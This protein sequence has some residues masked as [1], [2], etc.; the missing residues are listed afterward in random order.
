MA[1]ALAALLAVAQPDDVA[2]RA[3]VRDSC[4]ECHGADAPKA[5]LDLDSLLRAD[6]TLH[7]VPWE[8]AVR[9]LRTRQ[10]PPPGKTRLSEA[11]YRTL[12]DGLE[13][14]L[15]AARPDPGRPDTL[16]RLSRAEY[17]SAVR[18]LL[19]LEIDAAALLPPDE[20]THGFDSA[21]AGALSA[22]VLDRYLSAA[23]R[24]SRLALGRVGR[25]PGGDT[26]RVRP[27]LT[28]EDRL[29]GL[30][31]G[32]RGGTLL[33]Y[34]FPADGDY[35]IRLRLMRDRN[36]EVEGLAGPH[37]L[38]VLLDRRPVK[39]FT[40][41]PPGK[42]ERGH[43]MVDA[44][45]LARLSV[46]A[47]PHDLAA[48]FLKQPSS[49]PETLRQPY[50]SAFNAHRHPRRT[51]A[52]YEI[53]IV[54][55]YDPKGPGDSPSRRRLLVAA[56]GGGDAA[57]RAV[58]APLLR[59]AFRRPVADAELER[60]LRVF[61]GAGDFESGLEAALGAVLVSHDFLFRVERD[62]EGLPPR[63]AYALGDV[64]LA[65]RLSFFLWGSL[66]DD[67]LIDLAERGELSKPG[68]LEREA[69][70]LLADP[71]AATLS[72]SFA[73]QWLQI[74]NLEGVAPDGRLYP[75]FDDNLRRAMRRETEL[76]F[77]EVVREDRPVTA[78]LRSDHAWLNER[79]ARHYGIPHVLGDRFR[80][81]ELDPAQGR[82][83]LLRQAGVLTISSYANRTSPVLRGKWILETLI[84]TPP[85]PPPPDVPA[86]VDDPV[87][88]KLPVRE[89]LKQHRQNPACAVCHRSIDP[90]GF[91]L[92]VFDAVGR[93]READAA[94]G[95]P[96]GSVVEGVDGLEAA[97]L[98]RP[99]LLV[100]ALA[101]KLLTYALG[102]AIVPADG[103]ALRGIVRAAA[104]AEF[105][106]SAV[107]AAIVD[108]VPFRMRRTP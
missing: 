62:P 56:P 43:A 50:V 12:L 106:F 92:E 18:D 94:G 20:S 32:T 46:S 4:I 60:Y 42:D 58:L 67:L 34:T 9:R 63:S 85:P 57:A 105:R 15:D 91:P 48:T 103:P 61:H 35:D 83:G 37:E 96:D 75:D 38:L 19:H 97:L 99:E 31:P 11:G 79:L 78:L 10:M 52:L 23:E 73:A 66:P 100:E 33:R 1:V 102:R 82:G 6:P 108:S 89:R 24:I 90:A 64:E 76:L 69:R 41:R 22:S 29:D 16:R 88:E 77:E 104:A 2:W 101:E 84:G 21:T 47:G 71:R 44:H 93:R 81:V 27:D 40:V 53:S 107:V 39:Q 95:L 8:K 45:L 54:G 74:R 17:R 55:P 59:R 25:S 7:V 14:R 28:Q 49:E 87:S 68:V 70:R 98:R 86:L 13:A 65:T 80:R 3:L 5:G 26:F 30:P 72:T 36:E 51:P